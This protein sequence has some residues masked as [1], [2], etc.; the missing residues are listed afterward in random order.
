MLSALVGW[1]VER[2]SEVHVSDVR[3]LIVETQRHR[4]DAM[5]A[6]KDRGI[7]GR[8]PLQ[9]TLHSQQRGVKATGDLVFGPEPAGEVRAETIQVGWADAQGSAPAPAVQTRTRNAAARQ[10]S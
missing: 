4:Q 6:A 3:D 8:L 1:G 7:P 9:L 10:S 2:G 5:A